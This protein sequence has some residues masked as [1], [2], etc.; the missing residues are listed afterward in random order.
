MHVEHIQINV[1]S[2]FLK[3]ASLLIVTLEVI[4]ELPGEL[5]TCQSSKVRVNILFG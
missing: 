3:I 1:F 2:H 4:L 5:F